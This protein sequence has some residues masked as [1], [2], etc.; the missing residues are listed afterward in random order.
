MAVRGVLG[1][2]VSGVRSL[3]SRE[4]TGNFFDFS[5]L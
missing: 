1:E 2:L 3:L 5:L 4:N